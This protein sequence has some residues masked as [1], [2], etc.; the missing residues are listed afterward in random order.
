MFG[1]YSK[2]K[3]ESYIDIDNEKQCTGKSG[4]KK[5]INLKENK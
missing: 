1:N 5:S 4:H 2:I 3:I